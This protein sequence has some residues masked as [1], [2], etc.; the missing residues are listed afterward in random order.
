MKKTALFVVLAVTFGLLTAC[1]HS[2]GTYILSSPAP[3]LDRIE[4]RGE[5]NIGTAASMPPL[6][7]TT[8]DGKIIGMEADLARYLAD[9]MGVQLNLQAMPFKDLIPA[10]ESG[11][12]DM[13]LSGVT[14]TAKR[15]RRVAFVG[16]YFISGKGVLTSQ[17]TLAA[18][19]KPNDIDKKEFKITALEGSTSEEFVKTIISKAQY[20]P[21][22]DYD[23]GVAMVREG[24]VEAMV[25][26]H[27]ICVVSVARY[28]EE[29][30]TIVSPF[31]YEPIGVVLPAN[32][33]LYINL[34]QNFFNTLEDSGALENLREA[35]FRKGDW[36]DKIK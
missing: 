35:W 26:D 7:M 8:K 2:S 30:F 4:K 28:P 36:W 24:K 31:T 33:P 10:V 34:V 32:D 12:L 6:N 18:I 15:N 29:L 11:K 9:S 25:A 22:K 23:S 14:I 21:A 5:I 27:P 3:V 19:S 17:A 13:V 16:P 20:V 1:T